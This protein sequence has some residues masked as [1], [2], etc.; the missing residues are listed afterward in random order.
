M[1]GGQ[2]AYMAGTSM[3]SPHVAGVAALIKSTHPHASA[4]KVKA[5]LAAQA[6]KTPCTDPYDINGD[7]K[8]DAVCEGPKN[9]NGFYGHGIADALDAVTK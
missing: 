6:D 2:W 3:A 5:L 7:G 1:P 4:A 8:I 9:Y